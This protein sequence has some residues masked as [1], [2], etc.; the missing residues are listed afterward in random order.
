[1]SEEREVCEERHMGNTP[2]DVDKLQSEEDP[3]SQES[4]RLLG[5]RPETA[6]TQGLEEKIK[7]GERRRPL[8]ISHVALALS[9]IGLIIS[10]VHLCFVIHED[11]LDERMLASTATTNPRSAR[12][13][14]QV[15]LPGPVFVLK[16]IKLI[17]DQG[18]AWRPAFGRLPRQVAFDVVPSDPNSVTVAAV[19]APACNA[20]AQYAGMREN[21]M[22]LL[23]AA[24]HQG[25]LRTQTWA[26]ILQTLDNITEFVAT[27]HPAVSST[28]QRV[29]HGQKENAEAIRR[30]EA[31]QEQHG[32]DIRSIEQGASVLGNHT[33]PA[34][35]DAHDTDAD[36]ID[37]ENDEGHGSLSSS[38]G[39]GTSR[40]S[41][42]GAASGKLKTDSQEMT[43][44][45]IL[46]LLRYHSLEACSKFQIR[47]AFCL[48]GSY[49]GCA[50]AAPALA[51]LTTLLSHFGA[52]MHKTA[53]PVP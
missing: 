17:Q 38:D 30:I 24:A 29:M 16:S 3:D 52:E 45:E 15:A 48:L 35:H 8:K 42:S 39:G 9:V 46:A 4:D 11:A 37:D 10:I 53:G 1:M 33:R 47:F 7:E 34:A 27:R 18:I 14:P 44:E 49:H 51:Q 43:L 19:W 20:F 40:D 21:P 13:G 25:D 5:T 22:N 2:P 26:S 32:A 6:Q 31:I 41:A 28:L 23:E 50:H 36:D 12:Y